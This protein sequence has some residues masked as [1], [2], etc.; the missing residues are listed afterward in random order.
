M[1]VAL[2]EAATMI[3]ADKIV[4]SCK[5]M[6]Y[7]TV[8]L[9]NTVKRF[10]VGARVASRNSD[11]FLKQICKYNGMIYPFECANYVL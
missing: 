11:I 3:Q 4:Y 9:I 7:P 1:M 10:I 2:V 5:N 6:N 8:L